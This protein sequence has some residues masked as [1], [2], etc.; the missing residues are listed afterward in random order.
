MKNLAT[1]FYGILCCGHKTGLGLQLL[2]IK[3]PEIG[4]Q[5]KILQE[6]TTPST[7]IS[8]FSLADEMSR[9]EVC[10]SIEGQRA[11]TAKKFRKVEG[12][13]MEWLQNPCDRGDLCFRLLKEQ[14]KL[15]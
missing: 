9:K 4:K 2:P 13:L 12:F 3:R 11:L 10:S 7:H 6:K 15:M 5:L 1:L 14:I 8:R